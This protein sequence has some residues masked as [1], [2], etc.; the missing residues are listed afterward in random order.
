MADEQFTL[1]AGGNMRAPPLQTQVQW[2]KECWDKVEASVVIKSFKKCC[3]SNAMDGTED[4]ILWQDDDPDDLA[5]VAAAVA[6]VGKGPSAATIDVPAITANN[7]DPCSSNATSSATELG[8]LTSLMGH[9][10]KELLF[11]YR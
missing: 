8:I 4:D 6:P 3:I 10:F 2:V 7:E 1:T 5:P 9:H 11:I